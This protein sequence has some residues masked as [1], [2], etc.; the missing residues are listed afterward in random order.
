MDSN[1]SPFKLAH[2]GGKRVKGQ[3]QPDNVRYGNSRAYLE[4]RLRR[5]AEEGVRTAAVLLEGVR[6]GII[7]IYAASVEMN[8][9]KRAEPRGTGSQNMARARDW[10]LHRLLNPRPDKGKAPPAGA[11]GA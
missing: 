4:A 2:P 10:R 7:S 6:Q 3:R 8:Y 9:T 5:D 11:N 1:P